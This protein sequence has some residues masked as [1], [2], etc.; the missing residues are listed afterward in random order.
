MDHFLSNNRSMAITAEVTQGTLSNRFDTFETSLLR[1]PG[2]L[3]PCGT[4]RQ[5]YEKHSFKEMAEGERSHV[6]IEHDCRAYGSRSSP[7]FG[8][9][10]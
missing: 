10:H 2:V 6:C 1:E 8:R 5:V 3:H 7:H 9:S 4:D